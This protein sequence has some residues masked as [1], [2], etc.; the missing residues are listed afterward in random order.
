[1][2][3]GDRMIMKSSTLFGAAVVLLFSMAPKASGA[4]WQTMTLG[5]ALR[6]GGGPTIPASWAGIWSREDTVRFCGN[7]MI[8]FAGPGSDTLCAGAQIEQQADG[9]PLNCTGTFDDDSANM[10]CTGSDEVSPGCLVQYEMTIVATRNGD[11]STTE[12]TINA[13]YQPPFCDSVPNSCLVMNTTSTRVQPQPPS[14]LTP[15]EPG[16]WGMLKARYR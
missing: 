4:E 11:T 5:K 7:P 15:V 14:C 13:T 16:T 10:V 6:S 9:V 3:L 1:M 8:L 2:I 12:A